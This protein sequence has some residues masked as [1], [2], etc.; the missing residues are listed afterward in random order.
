VYEDEN[1]TIHIGDQES[2]EFWREFSNKNPDG[3]D[4]LID[5]G[6]HTPAQQIVTLKEMLPKLK[7]GGVFICEDVTGINHPFR[8]FVNALVNDLNA[9]NRDSEP[10]VSPTEFQKMV[11]S[12][13]FYPYVVVIEKHTV[14]PNRLNSP[15]H[16]TE[17]Q[18]YLQPR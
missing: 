5:D 15:K 2:S 4:V 12:V 8:S 7:S 9:A 14:N 1:T 3:I 18:P 11:H 16:G 13:H 17:W 10:G 6:G